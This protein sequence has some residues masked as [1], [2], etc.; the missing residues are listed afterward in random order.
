MRCTLGSVLIYMRRHRPPVDDII[1]DALLKHA[2]GRNNTKRV[3]VGL[4]PTVADDV[5]DQRP[6]DLTSRLAAIVLTQVGNIIHDALHSRCKEA[7]VLVVHDHDDDST[8]YRG[9]DG[10]R[11]D[12]SQQNSAPVNSADNSRSSWWE[13]RLKGFV[14]TTRNC[15]GRIRT[16]AWEQKRSASIMRGGAKWQTH[17]LVLYA[18]QS[19][20]PARN[21]LQYTTVEEDICR[22]PLLLAGFCTDLACQC[23]GTPGKRGDGVHRKDVSLSC[24]RP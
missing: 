17:T 19:L 22:L 14:G 18:F 23:A 20:V 13:K 1:H 11:G 2:S 15:H 12:Q 9:P 10:V 5:N 8:S 6:A 7:V 21:A 24:L 4:P 16:S 3:R